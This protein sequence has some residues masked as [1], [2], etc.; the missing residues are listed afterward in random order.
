MGAFVP[1]E[2]GSQVFTEGQLAGGPGKDLSLNEIDGFTLGAL[3]GGVG[4]FLTGELIV[5]NVAPGEG[6]FVQNVRFP[7]VWHRSTGHEFGQSCWDR[8]AEADRPEFKSEKQ[9]LRGRKGERIPGVPPG[10]ES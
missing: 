6:A 5:P 8:S 9:H 2:I 3:A 1:D 7:I 10:C 4:S